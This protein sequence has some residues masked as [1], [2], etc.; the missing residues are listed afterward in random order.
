MAEISKYD[1][2]FSHCCSVT[3]SGSTLCDPM[4]YST[5][6]S[7]VLHC[8]LE[9]AKFMSIELLIFWYHMF[10][11]FHTRILQF[12][13]FS[14]QEYW[15]GLPSPSLVD[16]ILPEIFTMTGSWWVAQQSMAHSFFESLEPPC[17]NK[18]VTHE[19]GILPRLLC[20]PTLRCEGFDSEASRLY[21]RAFPPKL[22][23]SDIM[24]AI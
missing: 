24:L 3:K 2:V 18:A 15:S 20:L 16:H 4:N 1:A 13:G 22:S 12:I 10:L 9:F 8:L 11:P 6:A 17:H 21:F 23:F 7:L 5:P 19:E 14:R